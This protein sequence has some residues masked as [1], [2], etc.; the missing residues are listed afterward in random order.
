[1]KRRVVQ[2]GANP[3]HVHVVPCGTPVRDD[4]EPRR[5]ISGS[6]Y[7][8]VA[9]GRLIGKKGPIY[10]L[11]SF[12][13]VTDVADGL[14][15]YVIGDGPFQE[16]MRQYVRAAGLDESVH[17]LG[18]LP[19][20]QVRQHLR[21][22]DLFVQHSVTADDGDEEGLPVS[23]LEAMSEAVPVISTRHAGIPEAIHDGDTGVLVAP[24][25]CVGMAREISRLLGDETERRTLAAAG[26]RFVRERFTLAKE[27]ADLR[28]IVDSYA[29]S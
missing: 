3:D 8:V 11:E 18:A 10:L 19:N 20:D 13:R 16:A 17:L 26:H 27:L 22:A 29:A 2:L 4:R 6:P 12:R 25:D 7:K 23:I 24:G 5:H 1:M 14:E 15:L 9:I 28:T 21:E